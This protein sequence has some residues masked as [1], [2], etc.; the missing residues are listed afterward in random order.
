MVGLS[1]NEHAYSQNKSLWERLTI[2]EQKQMLLVASKVWNNPEGSIDNNLSDETLAELQGK[3]VLSRDQEGTWQFALP[4]L[5][6]FVQAHNHIRSQ[7]LHTLSSDK[8]LQ[9]LQQLTSSMDAISSREWRNLTSFVI[10]HLVNEY[11]QAHLPMRFVANNIPSKDFWQIYTPLCTILPFLEL[12]AT[13]FASLLETIAIRAQD[14]MMKFRV[15]AAAEQLGNLKPNTAFQLLDAFIESPNPITGNFLHRIMI[16]I[17]K[18]S[19]ANLDKILATSEEWLHS[20]K[21]TFHQSAIHCML[22]LILEGNL[23]TDRLLANIDSL[24]DS[25]EEGVAHAVAVTLAE[26]GV[27]F[28]E[29]RSGCFDRLINLKQRHPISEVSHGIAVGLLGKNEDSGALKYKLDCLSLLT[30]VPISDKNT[31]QRIASLLHPLHPHNVWQFLEA[32]VTQHE[33]NES[34]TADDMFS[35]IIKEAH[36]RD[37]DLSKRVV[38]YWFSSSNLQLVEEGRLILQELSLES[39]APDVIQ[40][41]SPKKIIYITEKLL[42]WPPMGLQLLQLLYSILQNVSELENLADYFLGIL[43]EIAWNIPGSTQEFLNQTLREDDDNIVTQLLGNVSEKLQNYQKQRKDVFV[44]ELTP[45]RGRTR[46]Y[47]EH[48]NK[49]MQ[50][51]QKAAFDERG[52]LLSLVHHVDIARGDR[53]FHMN[54]LHPDSSQRRTFSVPSGFGH[55][56]HSIE[57]PRDELLD[58]EAAAWRRLRRKNLKLEDIQIGT[59]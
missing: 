53:S 10:A 2:Q 18:S 36:R 47:I 16:G 57:L 12:D 22:G 6:S 32:W 52:G 27:R 40:N 41:L 49:Q 5:L 19:P 39:F 38:T 46:Q 23:E 7:Q 48:H 35:Y 56:E 51:V 15:F 37:P 24:S 9:N 50:K 31:I 55:F 33:L 44:P 45:S 54:V 34:I 29:H 11:K 14:D 25:L 20:T 58:P 21:P 3:E 28:E 30:D 13:Y 1:V 17:A 42:V 59:E 26:L 8:V 4:Q 43:E